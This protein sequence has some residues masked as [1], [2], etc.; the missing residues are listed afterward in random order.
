LVGDLYTKGPNPA[1]VW[2]L[3]R[4]GGWDVVLGNHDARL[5]EWLHGVRP[6]D[7]HAAACVAAL[8]ATDVG[9]RDALVAWPLTLPVGPW[10]VVHAGV[11]PALG[12]AG[13]DRRMALTLRGWPTDA[14]QS[15]RWHAQ[16]SASER[17][18]FGHDARRGLVRVERDGQPWLIGL[19]SGCVYGGKLSGY[20]IERD[21]LIQVPA[22][23]VYKSVKPTM[24]ADRSSS[25]GNR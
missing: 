17:V 6:R 3:V 5:I 14:P 22:A 15:A 20:V 23:R 1:G 25:D 21:Q 4:D 24:S 8:D 19:D 7:T 11:H 16:Y 12:T 18:I 10:T 9:W 13:T 2:R